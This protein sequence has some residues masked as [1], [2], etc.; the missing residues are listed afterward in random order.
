L[1]LAY[2]REHPGKAFSPTGVAHALDRSAGA[3]ANALATLC[4]MNAVVQVTVR[5]K[6]YQAVTDSARPRSG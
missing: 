4:A 5:P 2:V 1:I 3:T 6:T